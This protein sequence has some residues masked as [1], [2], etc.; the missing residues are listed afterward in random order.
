MKLRLMYS[1]ITISGDGVVKLWWKH[2][3]SYKT[4]VR[5]VN[6][7]SNISHFPVMV[8]R[9]WWQSLCRLQCEAGAQKVNLRKISFFDDTKADSFF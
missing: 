7:C 2:K 3:L 1:S 6:C 5:S 9:Q 4:D 8:A